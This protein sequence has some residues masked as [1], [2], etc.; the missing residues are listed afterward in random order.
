MRRPPL[1]PKLRYKELRRPVGTWLP[2]AEHQ[3]LCAI[4]EA[5]GVTVAT[6]LKAIVVDVLAEEEIRAALPAKQAMA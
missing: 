6:Y 3:K 1:H 2:V 4:A 5:H